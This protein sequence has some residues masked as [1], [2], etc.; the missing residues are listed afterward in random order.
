[1]APLVGGTA[2]AVHAIDVRDRAGRIHPLVLRRFVRLDEP[3]DARLEA[4]VLDHLA[5]HPFPTPRLVGV[6]ERA[7]LMTR[8]PGRL[9]WQP[10]DADRYLRRLA[11][12]LPEVHATP[13]GAGL[14][15]YAPYALD[16]EPR[17]TLLERAFEIF[18]GPPP[19]DERRFL[20]RDYH[21]GNVLWTRGTISGIVDWASAHVGPPP[22]DV[23]HCRGNLVSSLG[24]A[25]ADRFLAAW[26]SVAGRD[27]Y[28]P[29]W[30]VVSVLGGSDQDGLAHLDAGDLALLQ[31][32]VA[33]R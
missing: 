23:G 17:T 14:P 25:A 8:L 6:A 9:V 24:I 12:V 11:A 16:A 2:S 18:H 21:P 5:T 27:D 20:H 31:R 28:D 19:S 26:L 30:D 7:V 10:A 15:A 29:Y 13:V 22:V 3:D 1:V 4:S 32:A 33:E